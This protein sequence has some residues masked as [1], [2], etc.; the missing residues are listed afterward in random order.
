MGEQTDRR[1]TVSE[2]AV[3]GADRIDVLVVD[4][5]PDVASSSAE[6]FLADGMMAATAATVE[7]ALKVVATREVQSIIL[8]H[9]LAGDD[10]ESFLAK[11]RDLPPVIVM[12]GIGRDALAELQ[13]AHGERLFACLA[14]PVPPPELIRVVK[15]A[16]EHGTAL[17]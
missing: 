5:D 16:L 17:R 12:S 1:V 2:P 6:I 14:K 9:Q 4:D 13:A 15:A 10:G 11:G 3:P 8:D 7:E